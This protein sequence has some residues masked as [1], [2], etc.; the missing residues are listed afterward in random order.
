MIKEKYEDTKRVIRN[1]KI[2]NSQ[3]NC[4]KKRDKQWSTYKKKKLEQ[5]E[6]Y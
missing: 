6:P 2:K 5:Y 3:Y 1:G 4:R